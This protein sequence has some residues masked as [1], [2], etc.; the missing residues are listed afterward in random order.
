MFLSCRSVSLMNTNLSIKASS[1]SE[2]MASRHARL[3][4]VDWAQ[5]GPWLQYAMSPYVQASRQRSGVSAFV[6]R[7][8]G[9]T[10]TMSARCLYLTLP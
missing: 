10:M 4:N 8:S 6:K 9:C 1:S 7:A 5:H 3:L 2:D